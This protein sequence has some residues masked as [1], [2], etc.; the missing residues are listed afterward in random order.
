MRPIFSF[1]RFEALFLKEFRQIRHDRSI[2]LIGFFLPIFL[3]LIYGYGISMDIDNVPVAMVVEDN[4]KAANSITDRIRGSRYFQVTETTSR[5]GAEKI[6]SQRDAEMILHLKNNFSQDF[7]ASRAEVGVTLHGVDSSTATMMRSYVS[8]A[9]MNGAKKVSATGIYADA[10]FEQNASTKALTVIPRNW[11]NEASDSAW[12]LVP[13]SL[14]IVLSLVGSFMTSIVIAREWERS[15]MESLFVTPA[16]PLEIMLSKLGAYLLILAI[17][18]CAA[19]IYAVILFNLPLRGSMAILALT[20]FFYALWSLSLG[21]FLSTLTRSQFL[22]NEC[23][24]I[25][26]FLPSMLLS[27]FLFDLR[28]VPDWISFIGRILPPTYAIEN[29]KI[30]FL[31]GGRTFDTLI[32]IT[33]LAL[34]FVL[35]ASLTLR[36]MRKRSA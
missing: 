18:F 5:Q 22:A 16:I 7:A 1:N 2:L 19:F 27:G 33:V 24:I 14:V 11:F 4:G 21:L 23:A 35:F 34:F 32:N 10:P 12:Y 3:M 31:S 36:L 20:A 15:T 9:L 25:A 8:E 13:G 26:C 6:L 29:F 17:G 28:C 30:C